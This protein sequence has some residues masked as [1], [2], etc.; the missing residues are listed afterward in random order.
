[1]QDR[2]GSADSHQ[3]NYRADLDGLRAVAVLS[4]IMSVIGFAVGYRI[5]MWGEMNKRHPNELFVPIGHLNKFPP[6]LWA[7]GAWVLYSIYLNCANRWFWLIPDNASVI[8]AM[9]QLTV[10][11]LLV[12][13]VIVA[14]IAS[15]C[16]LIGWRED[17]KVAIAAA[18]PK[19]WEW[20]ELTKAYIKA[21]KEK[22]CPIIEIK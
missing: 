6:I 15:V 19:K 20:L 12:I 14:L 13:A 5:N 4:V 16:L 1:M 17:R 21:R 3:T 11:F 9:T 8:Q 7:I 10:N 2:R 18:G 22:V